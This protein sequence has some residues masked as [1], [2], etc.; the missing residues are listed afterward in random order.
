MKHLAGSWEGQQ[1]PGRAGHSSAGSGTRVT[2]GVPSRGALQ[3]TA[4]KLAAGQTLPGNQR[5]RHPVFS[6]SDLERP[7]NDD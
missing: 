6:G 4:W 2:K 1:T 5:A 7:S 3:V